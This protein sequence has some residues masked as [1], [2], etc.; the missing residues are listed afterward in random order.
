MSK[1]EILDT[2]EKIEEC[3]KDDFKKWKEI[4]KDVVNVVFKKN[5]N[6]YSIN[7]EDELKWLTE[8]FIKEYPLFLNIKDGTVTDVF[9]FIVLLNKYGQG[10]RI[11]ICRTILNNEDIKTNF[12]GV[13]A[14]QQGICK[15]L[16]QKVKEMQSE[17]NKIAYSLINKGTY[18]EPINEKIDSLY[19]NVYYILAPERYFPSDINTAKLLDENKIDKILDN[20]PYFT[21]A[22]SFASWLMEN[23]VDNILNKLVSSSTD[24]KKPKNIILTG[25]PGTGKTH[26]VM[27]YLKQN[28]FEDRYEFVQFHPSYDYEDFIEGLKP[29]PSQNGHIE[30]KLVNGVFKELCKKAFKDTEKSY[31]MVIDEINRANLSRV[32][33]EL[34]YCLEYRNEFVST[35]MTTYIQGLEDTDKQKKYSVDKDNIG[36]FAIPDNVIIVGTMNEVDRSIDAF[37]LALRRRFIW[38]DIGFN[39]TAL[40]LFMPF[41][42]N[43]FQGHIEDLLTKA[44]EL[45]KKLEKDIGKNYTLGHTYYFKIIDYFDGDFDSALCDLWDYHIKSIVREYCKIKYGENEIEKNLAEYKKIIVE[46][47][48]NCNG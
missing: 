9:S 29:V 32:F 44:K 31:V 12:T 6:N 28:N 7:T 46:D 24:T 20:R 22:I 27:E 37:D 16:F 38:E 3:Y 36:K 40:R 1:N 30:F 19:K 8:K 43:N 33:G 23:Q 14:G 25:I 4:Y 34:L 2:V 13:P 11:N 21:R 48:N 18:I 10:S 35:K 39:E 17:L 5:D 26:S 45:N 41:F 47:K 15:G 42:E